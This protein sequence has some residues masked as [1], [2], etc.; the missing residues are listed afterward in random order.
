MTVLMK[1]TSLAVVALTAELLATG[2]FAQSM[3][4]QTA[5]QNAS[6]QNTLEL[7]ISVKPGGPPVDSSFVGIWCGTLRAVPTK[8]ADDKF[9][10]VEFGGG[11][12]RVSLDSHAVRTDSGNVEITPVSSLAWAE[13]P[14]DV[15]WQAVMHVE[16]APAQG[17]ITRTSHFHLTAD[18]QMVD[19]V[20]T[21][22]VITSMANNAPASIE[23]RKWVGHFTST[24]PEDVTGYRADMERRQ[25][26]STAPGAVPG[27][28]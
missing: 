20:D 9:D 25:A 28:R 5:T 13:S 10:C 22:V 16:Q 1:R 23:N 4:S 7:P 15:T 8:P 19:T 21:H 24:R 2:V 27:A 12:G 11:P 6:G 14:D 3:R 17:T 18:R 26:V